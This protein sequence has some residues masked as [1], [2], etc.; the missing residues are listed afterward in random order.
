MPLE[1]DVAAIERAAT[2]PAAATRDRDR[3]E[4]AGVTDVTRLPRECDGLLVAA[5][6]AAR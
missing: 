6:G 2:A 4:A 3:D 5:I 1:R